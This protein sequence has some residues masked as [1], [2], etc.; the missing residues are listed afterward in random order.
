MRAPLPTTL[1]K[2]TTR[3]G[4]DAVAGLNQALLAKATAAKLP[5]TARVRADT[6]VV[7]ADLAFPPGSAGL[8]LPCCA[9][10]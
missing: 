1:M 2:I 4:D 8:K 9:N 10:G 3:R 6:T 7:E 5:R